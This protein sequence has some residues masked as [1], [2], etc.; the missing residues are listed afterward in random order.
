MLRARKPAPPPDPNK[1]PPI[2]VCD[3]IIRRFLKPD[4]NIDWRREMPAFR[5]REGGLWYMYPSL[6]F[7]QG[8][9]LPFGN[10]K[11]NHMS[12]FL[13]VEGKAE[14]DRAWLLFNYNPP[15]PTPTPTQSTLDNAP[16][17]VQD[18]GDTEPSLPPPVTPQRPRTV[19]EM[20]R[21]R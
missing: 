4:Q 19:A 8:Y 1:A 17:G 15:Q 16:Q 21:G 18:G 9:E 2:A 7:W 14:M 20:M 11:L 3:A 6:A 13:S 10:G 12:W 5:A